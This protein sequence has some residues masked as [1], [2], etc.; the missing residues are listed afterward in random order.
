LI[1]LYLAAEGFIFAR[2]MGLPNRLPKYSASNRQEGI[3]AALSPV[4]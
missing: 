2:L 1:R 4:F 3:S